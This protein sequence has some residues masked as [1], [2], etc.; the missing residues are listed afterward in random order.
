MSLRTVVTSNFDE[1]LASDDGLEPPDWPETRPFIGT[2]LRT[3]FEE[4]GK[5]QPIDENKKF[6][7][8]FTKDNKVVYS[9]NATVLFEG[10]FFVF[11]EYAKGPKKARWDWKPDITDRVIYSFDG[12]DKLTTC[13]THEKDAG[14]PTRFATGSPKDG[15][16][17][18]VW[19]R[20]P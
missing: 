13:W 19:K 7:L 10:E 20:L 2:W 5:K 15:T 3:S 12:D 4:N 1:Y 18:A 9:E 17:L 8:K 11:G 16:Y 14:W 6:T